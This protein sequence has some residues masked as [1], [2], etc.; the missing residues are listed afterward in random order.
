MDESGLW[1]Q[2]FDF[3]GFFSHDSFRPTRYVTDHTTTETLTI[4]LFDTFQKM[5]LRHVEIHP[6]NTLSRLGSLI[7]IEAPVAL[8]LI[9]S[10]S[11]RTLHHSSGLIT[12]V[13]PASQGLRSV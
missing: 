1:P 8:S 6:C 9:A 4:I 12:F 3:R 13:H 10:A 5:Q 7:F 2:V 11:T